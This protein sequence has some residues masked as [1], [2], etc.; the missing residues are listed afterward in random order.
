[1]MWQGWGRRAAVVVMSGAG[2]VGCASGNVTSPDG[3]T[4]PDALVGPTWRLVTID[5]QAVVE[6]SKVTAL[7]SSDA[8]VSGNAGCNGYF[9][10]AKL[11]TG[12]LSI[13]PLGSTLMACVPDGVMTQETRYLAA[14][15]A[16]AHFS[17]SGDELRLGRSPSDVTLVYSSR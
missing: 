8:R 9:G 13:G 6:G 7:F 2:V 12:T 11:D 1:M 4:K 15:Q 3:V 10:S 16:A 17:V 14:L 5:G